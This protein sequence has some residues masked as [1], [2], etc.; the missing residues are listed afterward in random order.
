MKVHHLKTVEP[1]FTDVYEGN[2]PFEVRF[3]DRGYNKGDILVLEKW[4]T[5]KLASVNGDLGFVDCDLRKTSAYVIAKVGYVL[6]AKEFCKEGYI[7]M[8]ITVLDK[9]NHRGH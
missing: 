4:S 7:T 5:R 6:D 1:Y 3:N 9:S 8:A 2:K